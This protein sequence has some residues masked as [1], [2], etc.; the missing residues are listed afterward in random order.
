MDVLS[1]PPRERMTVTSMGNT[2]WGTKEPD[3]TASTH[4]ELQLG[5]TVA[6]LGWDCN[7]VNIDAADQ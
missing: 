4:S 1:P 7:A 6:F 3:Q 2:G 5:Q